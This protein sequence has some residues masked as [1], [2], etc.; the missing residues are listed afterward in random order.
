ML[1]LSKTNRNSSPIHH[2]NPWIYSEASYNTL[3]TRRNSRNIVADY[4]KNKNSQI[5]SSKNSFVKF[6]EI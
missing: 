6:P 1:P 4:V 2:L 3:F 5:E